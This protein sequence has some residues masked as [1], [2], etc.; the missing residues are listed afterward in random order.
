MILSF[1]DSEEHILDKLKSVLGDEKNIKYAD[2]APSPVLRFHELEI[3]VKEQEV[4]RRGERVALSRQ[5]FLV[6]QLLSEHPGW[7]CTKEQIYDAVCTD[8]KFGSIDNSV[9][10]LI[11]GIRKK[12]KNE[13]IQ[14]VRGVGYKFVIPEE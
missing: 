1:S 11:K 7:V 13:Y 3:H 14:T 9:Y 2:I 12:L 10:C 6:L 4:Y 5:E 8:P